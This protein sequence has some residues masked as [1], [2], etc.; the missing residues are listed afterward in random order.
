MIGYYV[1]HQGDGHLARACSIAAHLGDE[2]VT[3]LSSRPRPDRWPGMWVQL[4]RDD[5]PAPAED[6]HPTAGGTLHWAPTGHPGLRERMAQLAAWIATYTPR[7]LVVDVS[8]EVAVLARTMG[9]P[10]IV[11]GMPGVR[12]DRA[13]QLGFQL[14]DAIIAPWP[15]WA[16][17]L[18]GAEP[19]AAKVHAVGAISRFDA[20]SRV[21]AGQGPP[22][23]VVLS[24]RGG[25][26][27]TLDQLTAAE[28]ATPGW[29][30]TA[31]GPPSHR[32]VEDPWP[33][34]CAADV[35]VTH[36]GQN[37]IADVAASGRPAVV[38][39]QPRPYDEQHATARVL[40]EA[41]L[42][43]VRTRWPEPHEWDA[44]LAAALKL[45]GEGWSR[46]RTGTG[47]ERAAAVLQELAC[48]SR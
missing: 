11:M 37:A 29:T 1:H 28:A 36:A 6:A 27:L 4:A 9:V 5:D 13:H 45:G 33:L 39:P 38:I 10:T 23:V 42:A 8:V 34:L 12:E 30:W 47:A 20:R 16:G 31:L 41:R 48:A 40:D 15:E 26:E 2:V 43:V 3:G 14:A 7:L 22:R 35:I 17:V 46:W 32:W 19:W 44:V 18:R 25:T 24:G 21:A